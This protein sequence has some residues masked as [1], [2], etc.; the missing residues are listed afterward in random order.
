MIPTLNDLLA[1]LRNET[2]L[3]VPAPETEEN[4]A[5]PNPAAAS[6]AGAIL[7][8]CGALALLLCWLLW[9]PSL[10]I[11]AGTVA[12]LA[13]AGGMKKEGGMVRAGDKLS[14][15]GGGNALLIVLLLFETAALD[16]LIVYHAPSAALAVITAVM[17]GLTVTVAFRSTQPARNIIEPGEAFAG[18]KGGP[19]QGLLIGAV[20][21]AIVLLLPAYRI[22]P[23]AAALI[24]ALA[25]FTIVAAVARKQSE[26]DVPDFSALA[27][28][29]AEIAVLVFVLALLR[30]S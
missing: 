3:P 7:G 8:L 26:S 9:L 15:A 29:A 5:M 25:A 17:L 22:G 10:A 12:A 4:P 16:G 1:W 30:S 13:I 19:L 20:V 27:G 21:L 6:V 18:E 23:T 11:A 28:K 24:A 2:A 14:F